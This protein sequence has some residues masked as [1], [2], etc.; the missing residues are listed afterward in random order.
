M[1]TSRSPLRVLKAQADKIAAIIKAVE[2]GEP[3]DVMFAEKLK[4]ARDKECFTV[5]VLMD[6]KVIKIDLPWSILHDTSQTGLAE[7][8]LKQMRGSREA[9]H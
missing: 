2:R 6:D 1:T 7:Y 3:V 4:A 5:G 8:I 9:V